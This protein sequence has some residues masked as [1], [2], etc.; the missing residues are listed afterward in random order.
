MA[1]IS[2]QYIRQIKTKRLHLKF[3]KQH[4]RKGILLQRLQLINGFAVLITIQRQDWSNFK[5][6][7]IIIKA[8]TVS[9][10]QTFTFSL[11]TEKLRHYMAIEL[12]VPAVSVGDILSVQNLHSLAKSR[13]MVR[14]SR[15]N[16]KVPKVFFSTH[17][18]GMQGNKVLLT[19]HRIATVPF[20]VTLYSSVNTYSASCYHMP[21][22]SILIATISI[23]ELAKQ[24]KHESTSS[25]DSSSA[26][27]FKEPE[28]LRQSNA[29]ALHLYLLKSLVLDLRDQNFRVVFRSQ[30]EKSRR[31]ELVVTLQRVWRG[32]CGRKVALRLM[33]ST[34]L[35]IR[36][37][38]TSSSYYFINRRTG[39]SS[40]DKPK[41][42]N[43]FDLP[44][45]DKWCDIVYEQ[46][47]APS[48]S[49]S[50]SSLSIRTIQYVNPAW[51]AYS[52]L[53]TYHAA[54]LIQRG[55]RNHMLKV[56]QLSSQEF[57]RVVDLMHLAKGSYDK[58]SSKLVHVVNFALVTHFIEGNERLARVLYK[59]AM[60]M[61]ES[62]PL[63]IRAHALFL[64]GVVEAPILSNRDKAIAFFRDA[65]LRDKLILKF[66]LAHLMLKF[67]V[68]CNP[69][70][71]QALLNLSL[72][73]YF[74]YNESNKS[75]KL[76]RRALGFE[77]FNERLVETWKYFKIIF[78]EKK[79]MFFPASVLNGANT[80][81]G[82]KKLVTTHGRTVLE[83]PSW[84]GWSYVERD[85]R[86]FSLTGGVRPEP[87]WLHTVSGET[88]WE[89][90]D[91]QKEWEK[92]LRRSKFEGNQKGLDYY[93][94]AITSTYFQHHPLTNTFQ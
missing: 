54:Y 53:S 31:L 44:V 29:K 87:Y 16:A 65:A 21:S 23:S 43:R 37:D 11:D 59:Q 90:P 86:G 7:G 78:V 2:E 88:C 47:S 17:A 18:L 8:Y 24:I 20:I 14:R 61:S 81:K 85:E 25:A 68:Y 48:V 93:F 1:T 26:S 67:A 13:L 55:Y 40:W 60:G 71:S 64:L 77:P 92:R 70:S 38:R 36:V 52:H 9:S 28:I 94:D 12:G 45:E 19:G 41:L 6:L 91:F 39:I 82:S 76:L 3:T 4:T 30:L 83:D 73:E 62:S 22:S 56:Y 27:D 5:N 32:H 89:Q 66:E 72:A 34:T 79:D 33:L 84:A 15:N 46:Y 80:S 50:S 69:R 75:E 58:D 57:K 63:V 35:R 42:L 74:V 10:Q 51:G 49:S